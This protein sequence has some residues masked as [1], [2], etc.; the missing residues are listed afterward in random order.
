MPANRLRRHT[1]APRLS[2]GER[3]DALERLKA[4]Y[5]EGRLSTEELEARV[6]SVYRSG[7]QHDLSRHLRDLPL[8]G[9]R[10]IIV[11]RV[12]SLQR[13]VLRM[14]LLTYLT[15]NASV[16]A[17]WALTGEGSFWPALLLVP[18]S[19]LFLWHLLVSRA[20]TRV[21]SRYGW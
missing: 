3:E 14:H 12:R 9:V 20:L 8:R 18:S 7:T 16:V 17:I 4:H 19:A 15:V 13:A 1:R 11:N 10:R 6:E 2:Y 21:L 5:A